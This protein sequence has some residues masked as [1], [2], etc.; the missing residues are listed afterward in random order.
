MDERPVWHCEVCDQE[1]GVNDGMI[2]VSIEEAQEYLRAEAEWQ[3][4]H[5]LGADPA[6]LLEHPQRAPW[7]VR[8]VACGVDDVTRSY[9]I[10]SE[11][12]QTWREVAD[13]GSHLMDKVWV[14]GTKWADLVRGAGS[15]SPG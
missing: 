15:Q 9:E 13:W 5:P 8:H 14:M 10:E 12:I 3:A 11:R 6:A 2:L 4:A 7:H 1:L